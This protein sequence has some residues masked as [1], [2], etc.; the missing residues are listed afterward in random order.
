MKQLLTVPSETGADLIIEVD[1]EAARPLF[2]GGATSSSLER[3][4]QTFESGVARIAPVAAGIITQLS[5]AVQNVGEVT[6]K[7]GVKFS[8]E[9]GVFIAAVSSDANFE[10][11]LKW[12]N[13]AK[14]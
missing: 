10:V 7:F 6:V 13:P 11:G 1:V 5:G 2:R 4:A 12:V 3:A 8:A 14:K 9:A